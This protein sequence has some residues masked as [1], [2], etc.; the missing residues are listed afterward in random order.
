MTMTTMKV[1]S[2]IRDRVAVLARRHGLTH[3]QELARLLDRAERDELWSGYAEAMASL[4]PEDRERHAAHAAAVLAEATESH[5]R[6]ARAA[7]R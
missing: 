4:S 6:A 7:T 1:D 5:E 3:S 2:T